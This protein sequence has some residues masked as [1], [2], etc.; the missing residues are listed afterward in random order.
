MRH[1]HVGYGTQTG[2][3]AQFRPRASTWPACEESHREQTADAAT[4]RQALIANLEPIRFW[5][6]GFIPLF[7]T[8]TLVATATTDRRGNFSERIFLSCFSPRP[9]LY[10]TVTTNF[11]FFPIYI[12]DPAPAAC[13]THWGYECGTSVTL[14]TDNY[15]APCCA[16]CPPVNAAPNYVLFR[17][18]VLYRLST[19]LATQPTTRIPQLHSKVR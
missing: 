13:Y 5:L 3:N 10:F 19:R 16:P 17:A 6:C 9:N 18:I 2:I 11:F 7:V 14:Y 8:K 15:F 1:R 4:L 12:Y